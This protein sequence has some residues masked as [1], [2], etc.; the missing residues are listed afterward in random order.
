V[1]NQK[2][3]AATVG[4]NHLDSRVLL[5][6]SFHSIHYF[7]ARQF[8]VL[9]CPVLRCQ[10]L[11]K[12]RSADTWA[13]CNYRFAV[14]CAPAALQLTHPRVVSSESRVCDSLITNI[15]K[16]RECLY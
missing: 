7:P 10:R 1:K 6:A 5:S 12:V 13:L 11:R 2:L 14:M 8:P 9:H 3:Y 16:H 4:V 15:S